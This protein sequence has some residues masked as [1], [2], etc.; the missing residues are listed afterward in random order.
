MVIRIDRK[1]KK[2]KKH[3]QFCPGP[4]QIDKLFVRSAPYMFFRFFTSLSIFM[5][6]SFLRH[7]NYITAEIIF[8]PSCFPLQRKLISAR[9]YVTQSVFSFIYSSFITIHPSFFSPS[10]SLRLH[11]YPNILH[12][13]FLLTIKQLINDL[14]QIYTCFLLLV[15]F[16]GGWGVGLGV[17]GGVLLRRKTSTFPSQKHKQQGCG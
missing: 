8:C 1:G 12:I 11:S 5:A 10:P 15:V 9:M 6:I 7:S 2:T 14:H 17:G 4:C 16:S 3:V 13:L